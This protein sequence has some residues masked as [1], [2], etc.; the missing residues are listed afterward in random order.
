[1]LLIVY[2]LLIIYARVGLTPS[3]RILVLF[4]VVE[5]ANYQYKREWKKLNGDLHQLSGIRYV[6]RSFSVRCLVSL[7]YRKVLISAVTLSIV[8]PQAIGIFLR[9]R[10]GNHTGE[11]LVISF[12]GFYRHSM[13]LICSNFSVSE[14]SLGECLPGSV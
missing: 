12:G 14:S 4:V 2:T 8:V 9:N 11:F 5:R 1:M 13:F 6:S 10:I 3:Y 7:A